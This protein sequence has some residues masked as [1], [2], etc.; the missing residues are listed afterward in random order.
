MIPRCCSNRIVKQTNV[1]D[2]D[3]NSTYD[4]SIY[5]ELAQTPGF[6]VKNMAMECD[7]QV[8]YHLN[9]NWN[10]VADSYIAIF[11]NSERI[12]SLSW[13]GGPL[14]RD[15]VEGTFNANKGDVIRLEA[16][17]LANLLYDVV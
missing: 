3:L 17:R 10:W 7:G 2:A 9:C 5:V 14:L 4:D 16:S 1:F 6:V 11:K 13:T 12:D 15:T 8:S